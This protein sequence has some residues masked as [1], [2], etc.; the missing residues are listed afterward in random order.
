VLRNRLS[1]SPGRYL[2]LNEND[3]EEFDVDYQE[4]ISTLVQAIKENIAEAS[5][6][7]SVI[8]DQIEKLSH[9]N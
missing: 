1:L 2:G 9:G 6:M 7:D 4:R 8:L 5:D 3:D